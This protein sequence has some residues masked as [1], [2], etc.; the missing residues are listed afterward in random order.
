[1][2]NG[3]MGGTSSLA[4]LPAGQK[5]SIADVERFAFPDHDRDGVA[6]EPRVAAGVRPIV[7]RMQ[8]LLWQDG[9]GGAVVHMA[10]VS[11]GSTTWWPSAV[12]PM[13]SHAHTVDT[14]T[15]TT[16]AASLLVWVVRQVPWA[17]VRGLRGGLTDWRHMP[18]VRRTMVG[19]TLLVMA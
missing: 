13:R 19:R 17:A 18:S 14:S 12:V 15:S 4:S 6:L 8:G 5:L 7:R 3:L 11:R 10:T 16:T 2:R 1:M 9:C